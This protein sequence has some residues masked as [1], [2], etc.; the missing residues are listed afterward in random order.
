M[1]SIRSRSSIISSPPALKRPGACSGFGLRTGDLNSLDDALIGAAAA[2]VAVH[3]A[4]DLCRGLGF[5]VLASKA[6]AD[7]IIP[8][9]Q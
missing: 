4:N 9:V 5:G 6:L 3:P 2:D 8:E 7:M 1:V